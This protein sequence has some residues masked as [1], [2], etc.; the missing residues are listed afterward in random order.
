MRK[1][2]HRTQRLPDLSTLLIRNSAYTR[3]R[4]YCRRH[5]RSQRRGNP[6]LTSSPEFGVVYAA[7]ELTYDAMGSFGGGAG[8]LFSYTSGNFAPPWDHGEELASLI[9]TV[10]H[11]QFWRSNGGS[12]VVHY[13]RPSQALAVTASQQ[14]QEEVHRL[15]MIMRGGFGQ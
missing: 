5:H 3:L 1:P 9:E 14:V 8:Q 13:Y 10:I 6:D 2:R 4:E 7:T 11:P 12:G 15:L